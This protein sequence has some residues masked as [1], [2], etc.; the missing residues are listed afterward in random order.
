LRGSKNKL[1]DDNCWREGVADAEKKKKGKRKK[2][3]QKN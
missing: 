3:V 2:K 1:K